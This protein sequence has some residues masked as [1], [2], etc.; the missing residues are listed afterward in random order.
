[1]N[2]MTKNFAMSADALRR[3]ELYGL[4]DKLCQELEISDAQ[5][6]AAQKSYEAVTTWLAASTHTELQILSMYVHGS[7][8]LGTSVR[9]IGRDEHDVD[10]ICHVPGFS[11]RRPPAELKALIG[12]RLKEHATYAAMLEEKK[13][14][15]RLNYAREFHLDISP[16]VPNPACM[17]GGELVPD[18]KVMLWKPTNPNGYRRLF[19]DRASLMP[20]LRL[21]KAIMARDDAQVSIEPFP[22]QRN[23]KGI[24]R[25]TIQLLKRHRDM[26]FLLVKE[27]IAP[28]SIIITTLASQ[29]YA[30]CVD[31]FDFDTELDVV[32]AT[33]RMMPHFIERPL[34][35]GKP[36]WLVANETTR[37]ENF[38]ERWNTEPERAKAFERWHTQ[39]LADFERFAKLE[40]I[41]VLKTELAKAFG[42]REVG[43]VFGAQT[44]VISQARSDMTLFVAPAV[45]L[46]TAATPAYATQVRRNTHFGDG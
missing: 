28:I 33:I 27:D 35:N 39:A 29:A 11:P 36:I 26:A 3:A 21:Q 45:G 42:T 46:T 23:R 2:T 31:A 30:Y 37:G 18:K 22:A 5:F 34:V 17:N 8:G 14:C 20:R 44:K 16:T 38:A 41:D 25:R 6:E 10:L 19:E 40:G 12:D 1:M 7:T 15:W 24:L 32:I 13:R 9:P 4:F 43:V